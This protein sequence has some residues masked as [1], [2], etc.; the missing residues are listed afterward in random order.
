MESW[1][2]VF[3]AECFANGL[4]QTWVCSSCRWAKFYL[5]AYVPVSHTAVCIFFC[6][7]RCWYNGVI[8]YEVHIYIFSC[9]RSWL[10]YLVLSSDEKMRN[11][12]RTSEWRAVTVWAVIS[13]T[14]VLRDLQCSEAE[15]LV[16]SSAIPSSSW[17]QVMS[18]AQGCVLQV[19][20]REV[21]LCSAWSFRKLTRLTCIGMPASAHKAA[22]WCSA[23]S[24]SLILP[25]PA[26]SV[27]QSNTWI[28]CVLI[29]MVLVVVGDKVCCLSWRSLNH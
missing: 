9:K 6:S 23:W 1:E 28:F 17:S 12:W 10:M 24:G 27:G 19:E 26:P 21:W 7:T 29:K 25:G 20:S 3:C 5:G 18:S 22:C 4:A 8:K 15:G 14:E 16:L 13:S 2:H 11:S